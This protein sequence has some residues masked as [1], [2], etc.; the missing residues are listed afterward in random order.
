M[1]IR[2]EVSNFALI[3]NVQLNIDKGFTVITGETGAGKSIL[4]KA[5]NLLLGERADYTVI[6]QSENKCYLEAIFDVSNLKLKSFFEEQ[7]LDYDNQVILRREF[8]N[9]GKSRCFI[10]DSPVQLNILK[11]LGEKLVSI[12]SQHETLQ[13]FE[14]DFQFEVI[15]SF[16]GI[17]NQLED[18]FQDFTLLKKLYNQLEILKA[19]EAQNRKELDYKSF[20]LNELQSADLNKIDFNNLQLNFERIQ[21]REKIAERLARISNLFGEENNSI[22]NALRKISQLIEEVSHF[23]PTYNSISERLKSINIEIIDIENELEHLAN[24]SDFSEAEFLKLKDKIDDLNALSYKHNVQNFEDLKSIQAKLETELTEIAS[25]ED[26]VKQTETEIEKLNQSLKL[27][28]E[29]ISKKRK[30]EAAAFEKTIKGILINLAMPDADLQVELK[31]ISE[32]SKHGLDSINFLFKTNKG[33][34]YLPLK[35]IA[36]GGE[37]SRLMLSIMSVLSSLKKL[38]TL[39]FDEIDTGVSGDV[40]SKIAS[41]FNRIGNKIQVIAITH[42]P[43]V[44]A[45]G[46]THLHVAKETSKSKTH[47]F[48]KLLNKQER[49]QELAKMISGEEVTNAAIIN[50]EQLLNIP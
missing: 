19:T 38:P 36:S 27:K 32:F 3:E 6:N 20:L 37:L 39:I 33:G 40:A 47:T 42:L 50:A 23:D 24:T 1:L 12:H 46:K 22:T 43:Q 17:E 44:A 45:K 4:L 13:L 48:V 18:Y 21:H 2:F 15:D 5:L 28:A 29:S 8:N 14:T 30:V 7:E 10:N 26:A 35:K 9:S 31:P 41:E 11:L 25:V 49:I 34:Q 16:A